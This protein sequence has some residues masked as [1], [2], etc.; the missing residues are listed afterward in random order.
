MS[1]W[2]SLWTWSPNESIIIYNF[3]DNFGSLLRWYSK[4]V[5]KCQI[6]HRWLTILV[7]QLSIN[8]TYIKYKLFQKYSWRTLNTHSK[9]ILLFWVFITLCIGFWYTIWLGNKRHMNRHDYSIMCSCLE[10][11][12]SS[13]AQRTCTMSM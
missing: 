8:L 13:N 10:K 2:W 9:S 3:R 6:L 1:L 5:L 4:M 12:I 7:L 11:F